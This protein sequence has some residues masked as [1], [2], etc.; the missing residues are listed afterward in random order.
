MM[1]TETL[2]ILKDRVKRSQ[3]KHI[4]IG[5]KTS[6]YAFLNDVS[7]SSVMPDVS[8]RLCQKKFIPSIQE[9]KYEAG[10]VAL[11]W[12]ICGVSVAYLWPIA[13]CHH[14]SIWSG[15]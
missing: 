7:R 1:A 14:V 3:K 15:L 6:G 2:L 9:E 8:Y 5:F 11:L 10:C 13:H 4:E 12:R